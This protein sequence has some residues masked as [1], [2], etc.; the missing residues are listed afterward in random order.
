MII[1]LQHVRRIEKSP[2]EGWVTVYF[3][4]GAYTAASIEDITLYNSANSSMTCEVT[5]RNDLRA[6]LPEVE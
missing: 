6:M 3:D 5:V 4:D 2:K 1:N